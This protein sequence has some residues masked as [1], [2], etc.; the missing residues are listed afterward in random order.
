MSVMYNLYVIRSYVVVVQIC[1]NHLIFL[2]LRMSM[3]N[4]ELYIGVAT[5]TLD[6]SFDTLG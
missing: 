4:L 6:A 1:E 5:V 3:N 2:P